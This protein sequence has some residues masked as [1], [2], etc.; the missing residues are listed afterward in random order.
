M[1]YNLKIFGVHLSFHIV[2][3]ICQSRNTLLKVMGRDFDITTTTGHSMTN[4]T[5]T[6]SELIIA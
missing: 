4:V 2:I 3:P 6:V 5:K 1:N